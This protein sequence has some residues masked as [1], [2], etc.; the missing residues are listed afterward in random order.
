VSE[1]RNLFHVLAASAPIEKLSRLGYAVHGL[2]YIVIGVLAAQL[3]SGSR[4]ELAD[5]PSAIL[6]IA[7]QPFG[8]VL[9]TVT[10]VGLAAYALWR[11]IQAI[12]DPDRQGSGPKG[13]AVRIARFTSGVGYSLLAIFAGQ[14]LTGDAAAGQGGSNWAVR[15]L[16]QPIGPLLG[17][18]VAMILLVVAADDVRKACT[19]DFGERFKR[20]DMSVADAF[21]SRCAGS[22]GFAARAVILCFAGAFLVR[23]VFHSDPRHARGFEGVLASMLDL[24]H[25]RWL[26]AFVAL[27]LVAYGVFMLQVGLYRK[28]PA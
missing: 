9:L 25:G 6:A 15:L 1:R 27:G 14:L 3:A 8:G 10:A 13:L 12:A 11:F 7:E 23:A 20:S 22:W 26:L 5:P 19:A 16:L 2:I 24:P 17:A 4:G 21:A 28:H 18:L